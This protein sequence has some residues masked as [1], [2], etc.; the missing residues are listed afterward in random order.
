MQTNADV[1]DE[2]Y[3]DD[4]GIDETYDDDGDEFFIAYEEEDEYEEE[5]VDEEDEQQVLLHPAAVSR[6]REKYIKRMIF[7]K[8]CCAVDSAVVQKR[9]FMMY[10]EVDKGPF[11]LG[12]RYN[13]IFRYLI[14]L[15]IN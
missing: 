10:H 8:L 6:K 7:G 2:T 14:S 13:Q 11:L 4:D 1:I 15:N 12:Y 9:L 5:E 3:D